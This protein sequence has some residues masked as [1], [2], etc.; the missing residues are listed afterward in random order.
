M[1]WIKEVEIAKSIDDLMASQSITG[2]RDSPDHDVLGAKIASAL[3]K[4]LTQCALPKKSKCRRA[5]CSESDRFLRGR[6]IAYMIYEH[7]RATGAYEAVQGLS[8]LFNFRLQN[9]DVQDFDTRWDQAPL[10]ASEIPA[11]MFLEGLLQVKITGF[12]SA[13]DCVGPCMIKRMFEITN[14]QTTPDWRQQ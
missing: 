1:H 2:R 6:Q 3:K 12:C 7:F 13:S 10:A 4:L 5:T 14:H 9:D 11:E 8:D